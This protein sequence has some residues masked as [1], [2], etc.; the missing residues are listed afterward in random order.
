MSK[1]NVA[2]TTRALA[3]SAISFSAPALAETSHPYVAGQLKGTMTATAE[4]Q[5]NGKVRTSV[6]APRDGL[7]GRWCVLTQLSNSASPSNHRRIFSINAGSLVAMDAVNENYPKAGNSYSGRSK[8]QG[9]AFARTV[10]GNISDLVTGQFT[11]KGNNSTD[12]TECASEG[13]KLS[14]KFNQPYHVMGIFGPQGG[15][16][17]QRHHNA[18]QY[19]NIP[20]GTK[21]GL[22][23]YG[24]QIVTPAGQT[25]TR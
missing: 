7:S 25:Y 9:K 14:A 15:V 16:V 23:P 5:T 3:L 22:Q 21:L 11:F 2:T 8:D 13:L 24:Q 18:G 4:I 1:I 20:V 19:T 12:M 17:G 10:T 6:T